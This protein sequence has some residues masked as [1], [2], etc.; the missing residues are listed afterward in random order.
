MFILFVLANPEVELRGIRS[1]NS[2]F[3]KFFAT[4]PVDYNNP[5][6][7]ISSSEIDKKAYWDMNQERVTIDELY[8][9]YVFNF[10]YVSYYYQKTNPKRPP[11]ERE[12]LGYSKKFN[13]ISQGSSFAILKGNELYVEDENLGNEMEIITI[14]LNKD[15][16]YFGRTPVI[17]EEYVD[18]GSNTR[19]PLKI[20]V[21]KIAELKR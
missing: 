14:I 7:A 11:L 3:S 6:L 4:R 20:V 9:Y 10:K 2:N 5:A 21:E 19:K 15:N 18:L 1:R 16:I 17:A 13:V 12:I 8:T